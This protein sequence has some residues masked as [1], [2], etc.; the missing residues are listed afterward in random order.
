[1]KDRRNGIRK[2]ISKRIKELTEQGVKTHVA[3][4]RA[5]QEANSKHGHGWRLTP[6]EEGKTPPH[7]DE[8]SPYYG[9]QHGEHWMD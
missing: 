6:C 3:Q 8:T 7:E 9:H 5:R 2:E 1:M 4:E